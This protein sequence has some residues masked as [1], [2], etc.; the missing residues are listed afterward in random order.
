MLEIVDLSFSYGR[1]P[2]FCGLNLQIAAGEIF[3]LLGPNGAG[4]TTLVK[5]ICGRY[6]PVGGYIR[7]LGGAPEKAANIRRALGLV[8][9]E[10]AVYGH[11][12]AREN[13]QVFARLAGVPRKNIPE[14]VRF[15]LQV[16]GLS[17]WAEQPVRKLSGGYRRR[18]NIAAAIVHRPRLMLLDEPTVGVDIDAR[19][20]IQQM[21]GELARRGMGVLL[22]TH[23][24]EQAEWLSDRVGFLLSGRLVPQGAPAD[25]LRQ[26][27]GEQHEIQV[28]LGQP[29]TE[30]QQ[31]MLKLHQLR[32][33]RDS[34][35][36][37]GQCSQGMVEGEALVGALEQ[38]EMR[39]QE[40][41]IRRPTLSSL[42]QRLTAS[43]G[44]S[45]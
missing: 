33:T 25:L 5:L 37:V 19:Q 24:L 1:K 44:V 6:R 39:V 12:S 22:A 34:R 23:D 11:L 27:F 17:G 40:M 43:P 26:A 32:P 45:R 15:A 7:V 30:A 4:K 2:V 9:Q 29:P 35:L 16:T 18:V 14:V 10:I 8:P 31:Q 42:F 21:I 28:L 38:E 3:A 20:A 41:R 36:W 13:L